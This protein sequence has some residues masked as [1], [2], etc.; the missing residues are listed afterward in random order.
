MNEYLYS[1]TTTN[2]SE[3]KPNWVGRYADALSAVE[4]Y[5]K[6]I[7]HGFANEYRVVNLA[8]PNGKLHTKILYRNGTVGGK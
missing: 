8:E 2:D 4:V 7:D 3:N 6:F 1:V 5:Q